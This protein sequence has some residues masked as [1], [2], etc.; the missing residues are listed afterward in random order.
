MT[1]N[2]RIASNDTTKSN[3]LCRTKKKVYG[4]S[5]CWPVQGEAALS[6]AKMWGWEGKNRTTL[7]LLAPLNPTS[8][9]IGLKLKLVISKPVWPAWGTQGQPPVV[10]KA[11]C[12]W[13]PVK[14][15]ARVVSRWMPSNSKAHWE[16]F[17]VFLLSFTY[18]YLILLLVTI[19]CG[20]IWEAKYDHGASRLGAPWT[21]GLC[22][23]IANNPATGI[24]DR[25]FGHSHMFWWL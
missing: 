17:R 1:S 13:S 25:C 14:M 7:S 5:S 3:V 21:R 2:Q 6:N 15:G 16:G 4:S 8:T 10:L 23:E 11:R 20:D 22:E 12:S 19:I 24:T 9:C 18:I